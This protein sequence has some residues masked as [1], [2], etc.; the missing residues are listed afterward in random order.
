MPRKK[1][2]CPKCG[3]VKASHIIYG[4]PD[5]GYCYDLARKGSSYI[6]GGCCVAGEFPLYT[7]QECSYSWGRFDGT[8]ILLS[9]KSIK[10]YVGGFWRPNYNIEVDIS[11]GQLKRSYMHGDQE[12]FVDDVIDITPEALKTLLR[13]LKYCEFEYWVEDYSD[14]HICD[15]TQWSVEVQLDNGNEIKKWGSNS[16]PGRWKHFCKAMSRLAE[17]SFG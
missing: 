3:S 16:F 14:P 5:M 13:A 4:E 2:I 12:G 15:G 17:V 1:L 7:C 8:S 6:L 10:V 11:K 9:I